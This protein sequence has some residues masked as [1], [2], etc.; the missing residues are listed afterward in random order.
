MKHTTNLKK[1][2]TVAILHG[3]DKRKIGK[4]L[5]VDRGTSKIVVEGINMHSRFEKKK[6]SNAGAKIS[7]AA[8]M[9]SGKAMLICPHC[10]EATRIGHS[11]LENG[12]KQRVCKKCGK[13]I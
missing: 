9:P 1:G 12:S 3:K 7:F 11:F 10:G 4:I 13:A 2:D 5:E 6:G 8:H